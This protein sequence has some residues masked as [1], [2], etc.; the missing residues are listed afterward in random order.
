MVAKLR[1]Q[2]KYSYIRALAKHVL[3]YP[4]KYLYVVV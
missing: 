1:K 4:L 2:N 3:L